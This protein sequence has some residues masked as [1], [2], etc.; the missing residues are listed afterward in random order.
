MEFVFAARLRHCCLVASVQSGS[1]TYKYCGELACCRIRILCCQTSR[2]PG[3][4]S[5]VAMRRASAACADGGFSLRGRSMMV[6]Y[7]MQLIMPHLL[8][9]RAQKAC[10]R[11]LQHYFKHTYLLAHSRALQRVVNHAKHSADLGAWQWYTLLHLLVVSPLAQC[12]SSS[13]SCG[14]FSPSI[15]SMSLHKR[16]VW[17]LKNLL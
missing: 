16:D 10:S 11:S 5:N 12:S 6:L 8:N 3:Q 9:P 1:R 4:Q 7:R 17:L 15:S 13:S 14:C 2:G